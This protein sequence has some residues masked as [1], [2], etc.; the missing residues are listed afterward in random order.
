MNIVRRFTTAAA[1]ALAAVTLGPGALG[2]QDTTEADSAAMAEERAER[3]AER[4]AQR[5]TSGMAERRAERRA[6]RGEMSESD[7]AARRS[8]RMQQRGERPAAGPHMSFEERWETMLDRREDLDAAGAR[9]LAV[10]ALTAAWQ[11]GSERIDATISSGE[12]AAACGAH[13]AEYRADRARLDQALA[14]GGSAD[15]GTVRASLEAMSASLKGCAENAPAGIRPAMSAD[16]RATMQAAR[17]RG[18]AVDRGKRQEM[19]SP[20]M[21]RRQAGVLEN[22]AERARIMEAA[23]ARHFGG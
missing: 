16:E 5:D 19:D 12:V 18:E 14:P 7:R 2:A 1:L 17:E 4:M 9:A 11:R 10:E 22:L 3:R 20:Q 15:L 13:A 6:Q 23:I 8:E 21:L